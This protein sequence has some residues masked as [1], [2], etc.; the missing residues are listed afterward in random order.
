MTHIMNGKRTLFL[1][2]ELSTLCILV[3]V[4]I[5]G[6]YRQIL[7]ATFETATA[8]TEEARHENSKIASLFSLFIVTKAELSFLRHTLVIF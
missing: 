4:C 6:Y 2:I 5:I 1:S 8:S 7:K 3:L